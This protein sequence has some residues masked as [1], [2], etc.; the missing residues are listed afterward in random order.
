MVNLTTIFGFLSAIGLLVGS[1]LTSLKNASAFL[2][3]P[4][5]V[6]VF[7]GTAAA[8]I[9]SFPLSKVITLTKVFV[10]RVLG[11]TK[12]DYPQLIKDLEAL[13]DAYLVSKKN[14]EA[15]IPSVKDPFLVD[16][17]NVLFWLE[18]DVETD[19]L[20]DLLDQRADTM[21]SRYDQESAIYN[22]ISKFPPAFGLMG[23]TLG[24]IGLLQSLGGD[25]SAIGPAMSVALI[26]TLYGVTLS[27]MIFIPIAENL[28][29]QSYEDDVARRLVVEGI[30]LIE[31]KKP[32][33]FVVEK[34][35][36]YLLPSER[37]DV[38]K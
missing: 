26:T 23:T 6:I 3:I 34:L 5:L 32:T 31:Q 28:K 14:F 36:S 7:G 25:S 30:M 1:V 10:K 29:Q 20:R 4:S 12:R 11:L 2:D 37:G 27:N 18:S 9:I 8:T 24:M 13:N 21:Q 33:K 17:A 15:K 16:A 22:V 38:K 19:H 35:K